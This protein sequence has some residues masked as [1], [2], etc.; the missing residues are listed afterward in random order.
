MLYA[1]AEAIFGSIARKDSDSISDRDILIV[2]QDSKKLRQRKII[3]EA[4]GW[5]V[6]SYSWKRLKKLVINRLLFVQ[7]LKSESIV[8]RDYESR[9]YSL[10]D[11]FSP[12]VDYKK[13][14]HNCSGLIGLTEKI[15]RNSGGRGWALDILAVGFRN[16]AILT[17]ANEGTYEFSF[18]KLVGMI[19]ARHGLTSDDIFYLNSLRQLKSNY[20]N[21]NH[22]SRFSIEIICKTHEIMR[23]VFKV[24]F[25]VKEISIDKFSDC[26][27]RNYDDPYL[28]ARSIEGKLWCLKPKAVG[29]VEEFNFLVG[30][31]KKKIVDPRSYSWKLAPIPCPQNSLTTE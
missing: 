7:H 29:F 3:L 19:A 1:Q 8:L 10:L 6:A 30:N 9:L 14:I 15:P 23:R 16:L 18:P 11:I 4:Q 24:D 31:L 20:R 5:S 28:F 12:K 27:N 26:L 17:L 21:K 22:F 13:E 2:D 25:Q